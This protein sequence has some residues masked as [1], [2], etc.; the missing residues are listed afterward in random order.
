[1]SAANTMSVI[2]NFFFMALLSSLEFPRP[3]SSPFFEDSDSAPYL[4]TQ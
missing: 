4:F 2:P 1:M 3:S